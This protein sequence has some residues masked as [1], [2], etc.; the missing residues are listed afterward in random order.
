M[1]LT[2]I[3]LEIETALKI[4]FKVIFVIDILASSS[5]KYNYIEPMFSLVS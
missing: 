2:K 1:N 4:D 5:Q 3:H